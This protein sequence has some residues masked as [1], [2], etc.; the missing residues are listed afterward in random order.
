MGSNLSMPI[1]C[2]TCGSYKKQEEANEE[3]SETKPILHTSGDTSA[4]TDMQPSQPALEASERISEEVQSLCWDQQLSADIAEESMETCY[5]VDP[6][7]MTE[8]WKAALSSVDFLMTSSDKETKEEAEVPDQQERENACNTDG[9]I[10]P[11]PHD[12]AQ[13][14]VHTAQDLKLVA[15]IEQP[16]EQ[17]GAGSEDGPCAGITP[18]EIN[19]LELM[20]STWGT[21]AGQDF[22]T[23]PHMETDES[24]T[25]WDLAIYAVQ[26]MAEEAEMNLP[27]GQAEQAD[28]AGLA[29]GST[30][31][32]ES[33]WI[34]SLA[35][36]VSLMNVQATE[37]TENI[38]DPS[39]AVVNAVVEMHST[40]VVPQEA[41][42]PGG[43]SPKPSNQLLDFLQQEIQSGVPAAQEMQS[44]SCA[45]SAELSEVFSDE[46]EV[47]SDTME[48]EENRE[49]KLETPADEA[50]PQER[51]VQQ[52]LQPP[53]ELV[54]A[55]VPAEEEAEFL[56]A[57]PLLY[58]VPGSGGDV[59]AENAEA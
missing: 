22:E 12:E 54:C 38:V 49:Y 17:A 53:E 20:E 51:A 41:L 30:Q 28:G 43:Q 29:E 48:S 36:A 14:A 7:G 19:I 25:G 10:K 5:P 31:V 57:V 45:E 24:L 44:Q 18:Q 40:S 1:C 2:E 56:S 50:E 16:A 11:I 8:E 35:K 55:Q 32:A 59:Q 37:E 23:K 15:D 4:H 58:E 27:A 21:E 52:M 34:T 39:E 33:V 42:Y 13:L 47:F 26:K 9:E 6:M 3:T 46:D